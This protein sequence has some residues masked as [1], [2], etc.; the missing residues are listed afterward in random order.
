MKKDFNI[1]ERV[2]EIEENGI[3]VKELF[4]A[5]IGEYVKSD[6]G[7]YVPLLDKKVQ[8]QHKVKGYSFVVFSFPRYQYITLRNDKQGFLIK[9]GFS[10]PTEP[11]K[12]ISV[13]LSAQSRLVANL[14]A[15]GIP[16]HKAVRTAYATKF[17]QQTDSIAKKLLE[18]DKFIEYLIGKIDVKKLQDALATQEL[19][20]DFLAVAL[21]KEIDKGG[22]EA[23]KF[24][25]N[26]VKAAEEAVEL[27]EK[28]SLPDKNDVSQIG[29]NLYEKLKELPK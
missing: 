27:Q 16:I 24:G 10:Y 22:L 6:N 2:E 19:D 17:P 7:Y 29:S 9:R 25:F 14:I 18:N 8:R 21:K 20:Y 28:K 4:D 26:V 23:L 15:K 5:R 3:I 1:Y 12:N 13:F 11:R